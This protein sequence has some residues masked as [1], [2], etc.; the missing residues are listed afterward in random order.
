MVNKYS[1]PAYLFLLLGICFYACTGS[2]KGNTDKT[3]LTT[4]NFVMTDSNNVSLSEGTLTVESFMAKMFSGNYKVTKMYVDKVNGLK[5]KG[6]FEGAADDGMQNISI[7]RNPKIADANLF[8]S[9]KISGDSLN[10]TWMYS[11]M[12]GVQQAGLFKSVKSN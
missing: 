12:K 10:G 8:I 4:Y 6:K 9:A 1:F 7:N 2:N 5:S 3:L 11:T